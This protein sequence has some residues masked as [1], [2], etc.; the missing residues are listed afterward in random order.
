MRLFL[1]LCRQGC[2]Q[3]CRPTCDC[4]FN[5]QS[6][7]DAVLISPRRLIAGVLLGVFATVSLTLYLNGGDK[8][9]PPVMR[10]ASPMKKS[11]KISCNFP[12]RAQCPTYLDLLLPSGRWKSRPCA[13]WASGG[14]QFLGDMVRA[15]PS[16]NAAIR[17]VAGALCK[18]ALRVLAVA[19]D[20]GSADKPE[21]SG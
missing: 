18:R 4:S 16:R 9:K 7:A 10:K 3:I 12:R 2:R 1:P 19:L 14:G 20:R 8:G 13:L 15:V 17:C 6:R 21:N 11:W 5:S